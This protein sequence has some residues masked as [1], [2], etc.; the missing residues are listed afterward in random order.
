MTT[1]IEENI[2]Q[3]IAEG[4]AK[5]A[6]ARVQIP[7]GDTEDFVIRAPDIEGKK[8][9]L[10]SIAFRVSAAMNFDSYQGTEIDTN[11]TEMN[12]ANFKTGSPNTSDIIFEYGGT[13]SNDEVAVESYLPGGRGQQAVG[14]MVEGLRHIVRN[15][16]GMRF[17]L[18]NLS[19]DTGTVGIIISFIEEEEL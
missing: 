15:G 4:N 3:D 10:L 18:E 2:V 9:S 1:R 5:Y 13:Y 19:T 14:T 17:Q 16:E 12:I 7:S 11:G 6:S 8:V